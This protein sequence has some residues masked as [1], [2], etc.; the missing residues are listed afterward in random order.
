MYNDWFD[1]YL[2]GVIIN[3]NYLTDQLRTMAKKPPI[4]LPPWDP[5]YSLNHLN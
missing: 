5:M 1:R 2:F 3:Q 4:E